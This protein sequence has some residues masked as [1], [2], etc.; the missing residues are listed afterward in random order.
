MMRITAFLALLASSQAFMTSPS[1][2]TTTALKSSESHIDKG[3]TASSGM[4]IDTLPFMIS[5]LDEDNFVES[6]EMM[7]PLLMNECVGS[8]C[9]IFLECIQD[10]AEDLGQ[11]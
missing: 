5:M 1:Q 10:R 2:K 7:E 9:D 8:E 11:K 4:D 3:Y 6:L